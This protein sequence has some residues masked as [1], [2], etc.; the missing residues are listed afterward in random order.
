MKKMFLVVPVLAMFLTGCGVAIVD[1]GHRGVETK[2]GK[3]VSD[4]L[5]EG[6]YFYNPF[7]SSLT[8]LDARIQRWDDQSQ[9]YTRDVQQAVVSFTMNYRMDG[10]QAHNL[11]ENVG[12]DWDQKLVPH[13]VHEEIKRVIG[14]YEAEGLVANREKAAR[15]IERRVIETLAPRHV[16]VTS[17][18]LTN[19][20]FTDEF[21]RAVEAKVVA[22]QRAIEEQNRTRQ[23]QE[24]ADQKVISAKA[25]AESMTIRAAA[26][27]RNASLVQWEA[28]QKWNGVLP[29]YM[30]G[31]GTVPFIN[32]DS[33]KS[34]APR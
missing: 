19:I 11:L 22:Q 23:I 18:Q 30:L 31:G 26:L 12:R 25:E 33:P 3:V 13:V 34:T 28:V 24:Q 32:I 17:F 15:E 4:S 5:P 21:E 10:T 20:D 27:E 29:Q 8:E 2:F 7:T 6:L 1:T 9:T 16:I 14:L